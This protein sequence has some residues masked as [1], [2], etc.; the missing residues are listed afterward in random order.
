MTVEGATAPTPLSRVAA[1]ERRRSRR[2]WTWAPPAIGLPLLFLLGM[3]P[4]RHAIEDDLSDKAS[5]ALGAAGRTGLEV[6]VRGRD[7]HVSG[8]VARA[9]DRAA[10][11]DI[12]RSRVGVRHVFDGGLVVAGSGSGGVEGR[13]A[14]GRVDLVGRVPTEDARASMVAAAAATAGAD[15]VED[16]LVVDPGAGSLDA[17]AATRL[18]ALAARLAVAGDGTVTWSDGGVVLTGTIATET[19]HA[20]VVS[21]AAGVAVRP[22]AVTDHLVVEAAPATTTGPS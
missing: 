9:D 17:D 2:R 15:H 6:S 21:M 8:T 13:A 12:V 7:A 1:G 22:D 4:V 5:T 11:H 3:F 10:V 16:H 19:D 20:A 18:G 14:D